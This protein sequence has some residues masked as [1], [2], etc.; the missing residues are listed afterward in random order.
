LEVVSF[1][2]IGIEMITTEFGIMVE[3]EEELEFGEV[4]IGIDIVN[5]VL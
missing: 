3:I 5:L 1:I 4:V 2:A